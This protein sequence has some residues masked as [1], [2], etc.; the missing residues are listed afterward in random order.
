MMTR[1]EFETPLKRSFPSP[2]CF[3]GGVCVFFSLI[4]GPGS[5]RGGFLYLRKTAVAFNCIVDVSAS[6]LS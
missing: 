6:N 4:W 5:S 3:G 1:F 2:V